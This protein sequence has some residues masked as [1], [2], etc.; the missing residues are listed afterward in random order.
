MIAALS[1]AIGAGALLVGSVLVTILPFLPDS[2]ATDPEQIMIVV[3]FG[4]QALFASRFIIQWLK[5]EGAKK[6]GYTCGF[7]VFFNRWRRRFASLCH[8][9]S[10][11][12]YYVWS[13]SRA[14][15]LCQKSIFHH[16]LC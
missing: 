15:Y 14:I 5:S 7:L 3:G 9:A 13:G 4:G 16:P 2:L 1:D 8:L 11:P 12:C 6:I 10:R